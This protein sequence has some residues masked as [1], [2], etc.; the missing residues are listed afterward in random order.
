VRWGAVVAGMLWGVGVGV[1]GGGWG[2]S[3]DG[4][5]AAAILATA[6]HFTWLARVGPIA[7]PLTCAVCAS[8]VSFYLAER[9]DP[10]ALRRLGLLLAAYVCLAAAVLLKGPIGIVL[11][12]AA[13]GAH[14]LCEGELPL[15]WQLRHWRKLA[16]RLGLWWGLPLVAALTVPWFWY[17]DRATGGELLRVCDWHPNVERGLGGSGLRGHRWWFDAP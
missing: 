6:V 11:P 2:R 9:D 13:F 12:A 16:H 10:G 1:V 15:P 8:L 5:L 14:L 7:M 17:A 3:Q 4:L